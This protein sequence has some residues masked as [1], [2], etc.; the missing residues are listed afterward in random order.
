MD[1][2]NEIR[3]VATVPGV[4]RPTSASLT[5]RPQT[6]SARWM[7]PIALPIALASPTAQAFA[8]AAALACFLNDRTFSSDPS[9][10]TSATDM[11]VPSLP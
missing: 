10:T 9:S 2:G 1:E 7:V 4:H 6:S 11:C 3:P 8:F 5:W